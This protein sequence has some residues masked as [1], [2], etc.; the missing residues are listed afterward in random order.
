MHVARG[1]KVAS[2][3]QCISKTSFVRGYKVEM[4]NKTTEELYEE[5]KKSTNASFLI[6]LGIIIF[7]MQGG[8]AFLEAGAVRTKNTVNILIKNMLDC[9]LGGVA[10]GA[11][12]WGV[13]YGGGDHPFIGQSQFFFHGIDYADYPTWFFQFVFAAT[14]ATIVSGAIAER[15]QLTAYFIYSIVLTGWLYPPV[16][17]WAWHEKGWLN[18]LG[19]ED[20]AGSAAVHLLSGVTACVACAIIGPRRGRFSE[21][22][23]PQELPGH[24]VPFAALG[25]FILLFGFLAFNGGSQGAIATEEDVAAV[26]KSI[27]NTIMGGCSGGLTVLF[28]YKFVLGKKWSYLFCLNGTLTGMVAECG[29]CNVFQPWAAFIVGI[30]GGFAY[31]AG[32][33]SMLKM[34]FDD[35]LDAVAVHGFGGFVG[36]TTVHFF[37][38]Q[39]GIFWVG[40]TVEPWYKLGIHLLGALTIAAWSFTWSFLIFYPLNKFNLYRISVE[41]EMSGNDL[42]KHGEAAYPA[43]AWV[44]TQYRQEQIN[45]SLE[46]ETEGKNGTEEEGVPANM[47]NSGSEARINNAFE[48]VPTS[49]A[50]MSGVSEMGQMM[51]TKT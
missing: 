50:L 27:I 25:G 16:S 24:S 10:Y 37:K 36:I 4:S 19:Y 47:R 6:C 22:G 8:F 5:L 39:E 7:L 12:G 31:L 26:S 34:K 35:P 20:F 13:A 41:L 51:A 33:F 28:F 14:T 42:P 17:R 1:K 23:T 9:L 30:F 45:T 43:E 2:E 29:G 46:K 18:N 3:K 49:G 40:D 48:M 21:D 32:H 44:E 38:Y 11:I 15:C